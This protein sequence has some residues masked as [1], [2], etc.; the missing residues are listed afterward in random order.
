MVLYYDLGSPYAYLAVERAASVLGEEPELRPV[1]LGGIFAQRGWGS[2]SQG[3]ER[4]ERMA[5]LAER[6][7]RY[8]LPPLAFPDGWPLNGL[9]AMRAAT[10][11]HRSGAG[12]A[13]AREAF[14]RQFVRGEE[15]ASREALTEVAAA[16]GLGEPAF[17]DPAVKAALRDATEAAWAAGVRGIPSLQVDDRVFYGD[18]QLEAATRHV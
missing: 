18:D 12:P 8:G 3:D 13:F 6:A 7:Q 10:W 11:A 2:W 14:R 17:D 4:D 15:A 1:L 9:T 16:V 5:D